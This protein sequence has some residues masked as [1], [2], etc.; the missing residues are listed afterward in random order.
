MFGMSKRA[1]PT[2]AKSTQTKPETQALV[3]VSIKLTPQQRD[4]L[5]SLGGTTWLRDA[6]EKAALAA[7]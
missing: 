3:T 4:K 1:P 7:K 2:A 5:A 6:I